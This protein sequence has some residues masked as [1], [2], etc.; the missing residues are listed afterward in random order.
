MMQ[1]EDL[2]CGAVCLQMILGYYGKWVSS[3]SIRQTTGVSRNGSRAGRM[4]LAARGYG[5]EADGYRIEGISELKESA[6]FPCILFFNYNH[7]VVLRGFKRNKAYICDPAWGSYSMTMDE[8]SR[9]Y[10]GLCIRFRPGE[11][12]TPGGKRRFFITLMSGEVRDKKNVLAF[13]AIL[14]FVLACVN[15]LWPVL[16][17]VFLDKILDS[18]SEQWE[19]LFYNTLAAVCIL[20]LLCIFIQ[21]VFNNTLQRKLAVTGS[22]NFMWHVLHLPAAFFTQRSVGDVLRRRDYNEK[23]AFE[24]VTSIAPF[25][26]DTVLMLLYMAVMFNYSLLLG[27]AGAMTIILNVVA[28]AILVKRKLNSERVIERGEGLVSAMTVSGIEMMNTIKS[29]GAELGFFQRW[30]AAL[31]GT[32]NRRTESDKINVVLGRVPEFVN[33]ICSAFIFGSGI[34][35]LSGGDFTVGSLMAC[36]G[37][38]DLMSEPAKKLAAS[39]AAFTELT[40]RSERVRDVLDYARENARESTDVKEDVSHKKLSGKIDVENIVFGYSRYDEPVIKDFSLHVKKGETV[41]ITGSSGCGKSTVSKLLTGLYE[42]WSGSIRYDGKGIQQI[43]GA[44]F[45][46][47][48]ALVDQDI[49]LFSDTLANNLSMWDSTVENFDIRLAAI[50]TSL[51]DEIMLRPGGYDCNLKSGG[52]NFSG[53]QRQRL[54][55]ASALAHDP[56]VVILDEATAS[57]DNATERKVLDSIKSR[58]NTCILIAHRLSAVM[59]CDRIIVMDNG[60]IVESGTHDELMKKQ[61]KYYDLVCVEG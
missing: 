15:Y 42:P 12:F 38:F 28:G 5:L 8:L 18:S 49:C 58:G 13:L 26:L 34:Y 4:V 1:M 6:D 16:N 10:G 48:V 27:C 51:H 22:M 30:S 43:E 45:T 53:G 14:A 17:E 20:R 46:D 52:T 31:S 50:D 59:Q 7:F 47:C 37:Y 32:Y 19:W 61:G 55:I 54:E 11:D 57:L 9:V 39:T 33:T 35:L 21:S 25:F 41:A 24:L 40:S 2:E 44:V 23:M 36:V 29:C 3:E 56:T 60:R